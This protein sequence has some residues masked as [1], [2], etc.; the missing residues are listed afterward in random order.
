EDPEVAQHSILDAVRFVSA[1]PRLSIKA[2]TSVVRVLRYRPHAEIPVKL[3]HQVLASEDV[4]ERGKVPVVRPPDVQ[5]PRC[6]P[7][8]GV[9]RESR[10][11]V[12]LARPSV[13]VGGTPKL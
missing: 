12:D 6:R 1:S 5:V 11:R 8:I 2:P 4:L 7:K 3:L 10:R 9:I 13:E